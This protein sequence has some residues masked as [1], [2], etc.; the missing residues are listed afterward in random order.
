MKA[1]FIEIEDI[2]KNGRH[3]FDRWRY[4]EENVGGEAIL[5]MVNTERESMLA[6]AARVLIDEG[7]DCGIVIRSQGQHGRG[8]EA[9]W[10]RRRRQLRREV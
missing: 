8:I 6:K 9:K 4:F 7:Q 2:L 1:D 10:G 5:A 3:I